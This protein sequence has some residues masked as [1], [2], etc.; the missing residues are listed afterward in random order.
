MKNENGITLLILAIMI[1]VMLILATA[2]IQYGSNSL[3]GVRFQSFNI[4]LQQIQGK[5]DKI[6]EKIKLADDNEKDKYITLGNNIT[7]STKAMETLKKVK[8]INYA[9]NMTDKEKEKYYY[10][11]VFTVYRYLPEAQ[12]KKALDIT[13]SPG[14]VII[15]FQTREVI[16][17]DG[18]EYQGKTYY[19]LND[20]K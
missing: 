14:S 11:D 15:N 4:E 1:V 17:I 12:L 13:S 9:V 19:T 5:V 2:T 16:S 8:G 10:E 7:E 3:E 18:Y 6:Y 20:I